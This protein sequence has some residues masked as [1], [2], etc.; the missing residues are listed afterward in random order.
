V[1][2]QEAW[3]QSRR[4]GPVSETLVRG[5]RVEAESSEAFAH[6]KK[7]QKIAVSLICRDRLNM[8]LDATVTN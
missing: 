3:G 2:N 1:R 5:Q 6:L 8:A 4:R 7:A